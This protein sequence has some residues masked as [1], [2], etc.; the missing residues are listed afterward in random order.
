MQKKAASHI[1]KESLISSGEIFSL[2]ANK[3]ATS[4]AAIL[5]ASGLSRMTVTQRLNALLS[6]GLVRE[7][8]ETMPSGGRPTR[9]LGLNYAAGFLLTANIG[10]SH[11]HLAAMDLQPAILVQ[12]TVAF[13][14]KQD[15]QST[16][17]LIAERF[18]A[19]IAQLPF[20][21]AVLAGISL[22]L[23]TPVDSACGWVVGPSILPGWERFDISGY[24]ENRFNAPVYVEN[25]VN[26]MTI[27]EHRHN[28]PQVADMFFIKVGT[29]IGSGIITGGK[30]FRGARGVAGDIGHIQFNTEPAPLCRCG[31]FGCVEA[32]AAGWAIGR[33]LASCGYPAENAYDVVK[34]MENRVPEAIMHIRKA[35]QTIGEVTSDVVSILN[36]S[37]IVVG[38]T[39]ARCGEF[40]LSGIRELVYQRCLP[41]ATQNLQIVLSV[42]E[43]HSALYG[44]AYLLLEE[45][46]NN[47]HF[48]RRY[49]DNQA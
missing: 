5:S 2:I 28:Y 37:L 8:E 47:N 19:L 27:Y 7:T 22:S 30:I 20:Q 24:L 4:R 16:L 1:D 38:G 31:K 13:R 43:A 15:P 18:N 41:L 44:A 33:D 45:Q 14:D 10:E 11:I 39:L 25:D 36:P 21:Q 49:A 40:L 17:D 42:S 3:T 26:L 35:G 9:V 12:E 6:A 32:R 46:M 29:G 48:L 23:P 34:L